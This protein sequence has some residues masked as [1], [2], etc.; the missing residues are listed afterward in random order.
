MY[1]TNNNGLC[2]IIILWQNLVNFTALF[3]K[4]NFP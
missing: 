4:G 1:K 2:T 3:S